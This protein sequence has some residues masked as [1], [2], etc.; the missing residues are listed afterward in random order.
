MMN[1]RY[2]PVEVLKEN[3]RDISAKIQAGA[4]IWRA[5][6]PRY[7]CISEILQFL[8]EQRDRHFG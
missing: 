7:T 8:C 4:C 5:G 2:V 3:K 6:T 1:V